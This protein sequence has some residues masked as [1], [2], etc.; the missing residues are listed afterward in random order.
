MELNPF[1]HN[2]SLFFG[3]VHLLDSLPKIK[4]PM[5][6]KTKSINL[7]KLNMK[8]VVNF[9]RKCW[10]S[11]VFMLCITS[12]GFAQSIS[13]STANCVPTANEIQ[14]DLFVTNTGAVSLQFNNFII[15]LTHS[16]AILAGGTNTIVFSYVSGSDF[17]LSW[18]PSS[19]PAFIYNPGTRLFRVSTSNSI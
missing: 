2:I 17:P 12:V 14:F 10:I 7:K 8:N 15:R 6:M 5:I 1:I 16:A 4:D 11:F 9:T 19:S 13:M 18:P 3:R